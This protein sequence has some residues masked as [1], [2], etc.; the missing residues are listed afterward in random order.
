MIILANL[1][2][3]NQKAL[4]TKKEPEE[5][6]KKVQISALFLYHVISEVNA[7]KKYE[8]FSGHYIFSGAEIPKIVSPF[9]STTCIDLISTS[10]ALESSTFSCIIL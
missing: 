10:L 4:N 6:L 3:K 2:F 7:K 5:Y 1:E 9:L 8:E